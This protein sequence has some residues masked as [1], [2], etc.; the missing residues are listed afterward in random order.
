MRTVTLGLTALV[1]AVL[2]AVGAAGAAWATFTGTSSSPVSVATLQLQ[3][4][5]SV[6]RT[7]C[8]GGRDRTLGVGFTASPSVQVVANRP[9]SSP[10]RVLT[11]NVTVTT[12]GVTG[13]S[14]GTLT[15]DRTGFSVTRN[16]GN[17]SSARQWTVRITT[18]FAGWT[19]AAVATTLNC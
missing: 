3:P 18:S 17:G 5:S 6:V 4:P 8:S 2:M 16:V 15:A 11:Y 10:A 13:A 1:L 9:P 7:S 12:S 19:S 14:T